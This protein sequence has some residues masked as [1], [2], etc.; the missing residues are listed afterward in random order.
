MQRRSLA[1]ERIAACSLN[2]SAGAAAFCFASVMEQTRLPA[3]AAGRAE[4]SRRERKARSPH[5][6]RAPHGISDVHAPR[7]CTGGRP[8][9]TGTWFSQRAGERTRRQGK[10]KPELLIASLTFNNIG[11]SRGYVGNGTAGVPGHFARTLSASALN[12]SLFT[13]HGSFLP[14]RLHLGDFARAKLL[15][16]YGVLGTEIFLIYALKW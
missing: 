13:S 4:A 10:N 12:V 5:Q 7:H 2:P 14:V 8:R 11:P 16:G 1:G 9:P 3:P 15:Y 6:R